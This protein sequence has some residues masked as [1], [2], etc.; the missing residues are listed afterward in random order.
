MRKSAAFFL[1][2][3]YYG[4]SMTFEIYFLIR[5]VSKINN[6]RYRR[7]MNYLN[8]L[9]KCLRRLDIFSRGKIREQDLISLLYLGYH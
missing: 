3:K 9:R 1:V 2:N 6:K 7:K 5:S 8:L 4:N